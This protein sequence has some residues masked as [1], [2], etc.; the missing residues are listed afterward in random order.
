M[1]G[2]LQKSRSLMSHRRRSSC[3]IL[4]LPLL[5]SKSPHHARENV[6][7]QRSLSMITDEV[8][9]V[10]LSVRGRRQRAQA[11]R[12]RLPATV[13]EVLGPL[14]TEFVRNYKSRLFGGSL[15]A[16]SDLCVWR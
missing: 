14:V 10:G 8:A 4:S 1:P 15:V 3:F 2:Y 11:R 7:R 5:L 16:A 6:G 9:S 12:E 13:N